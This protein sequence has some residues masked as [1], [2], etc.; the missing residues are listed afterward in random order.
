MCMYM[1]IYIYIYMYMGEASE[2]RALKIDENRLFG[3]FL[4][5]PYILRSRLMYAYFNI[6]CMFKSN[7]PSICVQIC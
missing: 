4:D 3:L 2:V 5:I 7:I 1:F 6:E